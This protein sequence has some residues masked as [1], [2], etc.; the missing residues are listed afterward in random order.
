MLWLEH[1]ELTF[2]ILCFY[3]WLNRNLLTFSGLNFFLLRITGK[4]QTME[5][6]MR[7]RVA[8]CVAQALDF[9]SGG[10]FTSYNKLNAYSVLFNKVYI[11]V[12]PNN[13][14]M[15]KPSCWLKNFFFNG[16][17]RMV[18]L[19]Y[20]VLGWWRSSKMIKEQPVTI[21]TFYSV[22]CY[23]FLSEYDGKLSL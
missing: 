7:L 22:C 19:V 6:E 4:N 8:F 16:Y 15:T 9:C 18:M 11:I 12:L 14:F 5:W 10:G 1:M 21:C 13:I 20:P 2:I 17:G 3:N 23:L